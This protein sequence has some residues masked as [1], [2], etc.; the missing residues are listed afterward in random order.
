[1]YSRF[2]STAITLDSLADKLKLPLSNVVVK[3]DVEG[4][5]SI[6]FEGAHALLREAKE[7]ILEIHKPCQPS[8]DALESTLLKNGFGLMR[9]VYV[10]TQKIK[11][12]IIASRDSFPPAPNSHSMKVVY[13]EP[14]NMNSLMR[15]MGN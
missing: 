14:K 5:E 7:V 6:L 13:N 2:S 12:H 1:M 3:I 4:A 10:A 15:N 8:L 9:I 11:Y